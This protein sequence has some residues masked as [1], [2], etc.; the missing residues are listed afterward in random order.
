[1]MRVATYARLIRPGDVLAIDGTPR[2]VRDVKVA[3]KLLNI[4][5]DEPRGT[6]LLRPM[7]VVD[8]YVP[9]D[10]EGPERLKALFP[11]G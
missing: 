4:V 11:L 10:G 5:I 1:M 9:G 3:G 2:P 6:V 8:Q 7:T